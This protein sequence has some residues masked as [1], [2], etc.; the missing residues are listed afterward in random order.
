MR[1]QP[2]YLNLF[3]LKFPVTAIASILH[4]VSGILLFLLIPYFL[5]LLDRL[6]VNSNLIL[7]VE[8][9]NNYYIEKF[10]WW[11]GLSALSYHF[12]AGF[13]HIVMDLGIGE[14]KAMARISAYIVIVISVL[15][16]ILIGARLC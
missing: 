4:R 16:S 11:L 14:S 10:F 12:L 2:V 7:I 9:P 13:R 5:V 3:A 15:L 6:H 1:P 8:P